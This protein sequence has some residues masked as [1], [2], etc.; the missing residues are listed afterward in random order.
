MGRGPGTLD[1]LGMVMRDFGNPIGIG[2][3]LIQRFRQ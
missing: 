1:T 3:S 2:Q